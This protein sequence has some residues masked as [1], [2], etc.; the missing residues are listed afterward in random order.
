[1]AVKATTTYEACDEDGTITFRQ[2]DTNHVLIE[3]VSASDTDD[4]MSIMI[5][6]SDLYQIARAIGPTDVPGSGDR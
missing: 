1:M 2:A 4:K 5:S 3:I 6:R